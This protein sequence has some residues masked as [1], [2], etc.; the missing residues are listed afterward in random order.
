[1]PEYIFSVIRPNGFM[2]EKDS[3]AK[4]TRFGRIEGVTKK[5]A[6]GFWLKFRLS[7]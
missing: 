2:F 1:M 7:Q 4:C 3:G 5:K 6:S